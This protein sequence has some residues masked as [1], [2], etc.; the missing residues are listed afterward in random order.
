MEKSCQGLI[1]AL[2]LNPK[3]HVA[4]VGGGG[5]STLCFALAEALGLSGARVI[6]T[7]TTKVWHE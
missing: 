6:S 7:T 4:V 3:E 5:K 1:T 2:G